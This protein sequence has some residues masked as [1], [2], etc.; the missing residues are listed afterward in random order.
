MPVPQ[1]HSAVWRSPWELLNCIAAGFYRGAW[2]SCSL[3]SKRHRIDG[4]PAMSAEDSRPSTASQGL[5][6]GI[7]QSRAAAGGAFNR[8]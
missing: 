2:T 7:F 5:L 6:Q 1:S 3:L 4:L 8:S